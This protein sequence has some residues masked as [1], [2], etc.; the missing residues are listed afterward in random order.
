MTIDEMVNG[1]Q[2]VTSGDKDDFPVNSLYLS[3]LGRSWR[4]CSGDS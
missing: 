3:S 2:M 1:N 4:R